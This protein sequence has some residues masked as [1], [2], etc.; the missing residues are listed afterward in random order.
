MGAVVVGAVNRKVVA[1]EL[2]ESAVIQ[3][4]EAM[5]VTPAVTDLGNLKRHCAPGVTIFVGD[6]FSLTSEIIGTVDAT[7][8]RA[9][10]VAL[11]DAMRRRYAKHLMAITQKAPQLLV[12]IEYDQ[13]QHDGPPFAISEDMVRE[14]YIENYTCE[15]LER[16]TMPDGLKGKCEAWESVWLLK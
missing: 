16:Q 1:A 6:V 10:L 15:L 7:Y 12:A 3:L 8:D 4:F 14:L 11:P 13:S 2:N 9:A 5:K